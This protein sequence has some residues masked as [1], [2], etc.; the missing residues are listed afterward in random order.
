MRQR[1]GPIQRV[2]IEDGSA[3]EK[4][5]KTTHAAPKLVSRPSPYTLHRPCDLHHGHDKTSHSDPT[6]MQHC[7][8]NSAEAKTNSCKHESALESVIA[9]Q[10]KILF[11]VSVNTSTHP[12][13]LAQRSDMCCSPPPC[14]NPHCQGP[15]TATRHGHCPRC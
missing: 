14:C 12:K 6:T 7:P 3:M 15:S 8:D 2:S 1:C 11:R 13:N 5:M 9:T 10:Q 4:P